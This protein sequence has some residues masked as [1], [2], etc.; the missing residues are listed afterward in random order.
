V[1]ASIADKWAPTGCSAPL[2]GLPALPALPAAG[3]T[4]TTLP[5]GCRLQP[6]CCLTH[7][8]Y[9]W[10]PQP[11]SAVS[12]SCCR[13]LGKQNAPPSPPPAK[14]S[15]TSTPPGTHPSRPR[16]RP[17]PC[18]L[19]D[20]GLPTPF[21]RRLFHVLTSLGFALAVAPLACMAR[22]SVPLATACLTAASALYA[23]SFGGFHAYLQV[24]GRAG[25]RPL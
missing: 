17:R 7:L 23:C 12:N 14:K 18:R 3:R 9:E 10:R 15:S 19:I 16:P 22:P 25:Q 11:C 24:P 1:S 6:R 20:R 21:V 2:P 8:A 13:Q 5:A 4:A